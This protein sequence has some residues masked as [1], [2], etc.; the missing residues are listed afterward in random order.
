MITKSYILANLNALDKHYRNTSSP[1]DSLFYSKLALLELCGWIEESMDD[2]I[3]KCGSRKLKVGSNKNYVEK[4]IVKRTHGFDY[5][6]N[7]RFM[8]IRLI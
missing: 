8:L 7:F 6:V 2:V 3:L 5:E 4:M 1:K